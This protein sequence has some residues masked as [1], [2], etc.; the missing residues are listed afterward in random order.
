MIHN[1]IW[2]VFMKDMNDLN[3]VYDLSIIFTFSGF[4]E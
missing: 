3:Y 2:Y 4:G 1:P